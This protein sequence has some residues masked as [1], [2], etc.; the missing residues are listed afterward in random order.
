MNK[1]I[2]LIFLFFIFSL[3]S[4]KDNRTDYQKANDYFKHKKDEKA[5]IYFR[6]SIK[7]GI[8]DSPILYKK[9]ARSYINIGKFK[10]GEY[11]I[12]KALILSPNDD[13]LDIL[14][15]QIL[16]KRKEYYKATY[17]L[18]K[19]PNSFDKYYQ[20][21]NI[22]FLAHNIKV[23]F[24]NLNK[25]LTFLDTNE[26]KIKEKYKFALK[27]LTQEE[28]CIE[29]NKIFN[30]LS[31]HFKNDIPFLKNYYT[32]LNC[33][34]KNTLDNRA[35]IKRYNETKKQRDSIRYKILTKIIK[36]TPNKFYYNQLAQ[37][38]IDK[39]D[40][41]SARK[42]ISESRFQ[43]T[44]QNILLFLEAQIDFGEERY[45]SVI[46]KLEKY[47]KKEDNIKALKFLA[48]AE[49]LNGNNYSAIKYYK[50]LIKKDPYNKDHL[51]KL[52]ELYA[53]VGDKKALT[54]IKY[55][56]KFFHRKFYK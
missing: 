19:L 34:Y 6:K 16:L 35:I 50:Q 45:E 53:L 54:D 8:K 5:I 15:S 32:A 13:T 1:L 11:Y 7:S 9:L 47:F 30:E 43:K 10:E 41:T 20:L 2:Y 42:Y 25:A 33:K 55:K 27:I 46:S 52:E 14:Y 51:Y 28:I 4:C 29:K 39:K 24:S 26:E 40:F 48:K 56:I 36:K 17:R 12:K 18:K 3:Y 44:N 31:P 37:L 23:A 21:A 22:Y 49:S 38:S